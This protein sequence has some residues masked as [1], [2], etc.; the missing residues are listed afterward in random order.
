MPSLSA[1][2][3]S[4]VGLPIRPRAKGAVIVCAT[5]VTDLLRDDAGRVI[6][7]KTDRAEGD[8]RAKVVFLADGVNSPLAAKTGF[9]P[10]VRPENV[11]LAVKELIAIPE[12]VIDERFG[13]SP[14]NG[15]TY[16]ILGDV[17]LGMNGVAFLY[18]NRKS[19]SI[20]IG[21]NLADFA[22]AK[23]PSL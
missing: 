1:G 5:V 8:L 15:V 23:G 10:E 4:I 16:E 21:A 12:E 2:L 13:V 17:T 19:I 11:A 22:T 20:G 7:V 18:T 9:R 14:G 6:G 3:N